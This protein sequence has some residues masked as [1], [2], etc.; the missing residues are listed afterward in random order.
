MQPTSVD[1]VGY[2][3]LLLQL[4]SSLLHEHALTR[5]PIMTFRYDRLN[6]PDRE[7]RIAVLQPGTFDDPLVVHFDR[8]DLAVLTP[9][10]L[11]ASMMLTVQK[12]GYPA[13]EA[14][15][16]VWGSEED[17]SHVKVNSPKKTG[18]VPITKNLDVALRHLRYE[19]TS[20][21]LWIDSIC[22][23]QSNNAEKSKQ[24][25]AMG[26]IF[27]TADRVTAWLG[28][29]E[30]NSDLAMAWFPIIERSLD[31]D[32]KSDTMRPRKREETE[33]RTG[34]QEQK[35]ADL[36]DFIAGRGFFPW[37]VEEA[38]AVYLLF[39]RPYF[40]RAWTVQEIRLAKHVF[41]QCGE[42]TISERSL[43][44]SA[45]LLD[46]NFKLN[47]GITSFERWTQARGRVFLLADFRM[48]G[49]GET[50]FTLRR[51]L[52]YL[53]CNDPRDKIYSVLRLMDSST[54]KLTI[55]PT[56]TQPTEQVYTD[57]ARRAIIQWSDLEVLNDCEL[58]SRL[59]NI[60]SWVPD[61]STPAQTTYA[62]T[63]WSACAYIA[64]RPSF[65]ASGLQC[66]V[67]GVFK[68]RIV[69]V[70]DQGDLKF[71]MSD[72]ELWK[73]IRSWRPAKESLNDI[74][75]TG[76]GLLEV[77]CRILVWNAFSERRLSF[78]QSLASLE[79]VWCGDARSSEHEFT[80]NLADKTSYFRRLAV[81]TR[82]RRLFK[83]SGGHLGLG[84]ADVRADDVVCILLGCRYPVILRLAA[85]RKYE[86]V[87]TCY[88]HGLMYGEILYD[89]EWTRKDNLHLHPVDPETG[90]SRHTTKGLLEKAGVRVDGKQ[91]EYPWTSSVSNETLLAAGIQ[92]EDFVLV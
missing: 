26:T 34:Q 61:W 14:L 28:S 13:Y 71:E 48:R 22:I 35:T 75:L 58:S 30:N 11:K 45:K 29:K 41:F 44:I 59:L 18:E 90:R 10:V 83:T 60:P 36:I 6:R 42:A 47:A 32:W 1:A 72:D 46:S 38:E 39:S 8:R 78:A 88:A 50:I 62:A 40:G 51:N 19:E 17:P 55:V 82:N 73:T 79:K 70:M 9:L 57:L 2:G 52:G 37:T 7:I 31:V 5:S 20:R 86:V 4:C 76:E 77:Y 87:G 69:E 85:D 92:V 3:C 81:I 64:G 25:A 65:D 21:Y 33:K 68:S 56:Y 63:E 80:R 23:N 53:L 12:K 43:W 15:S 54:Q 49:V 89:N 91:K 66:T 84:P 24:V 16:Y 67:S 27:K 74:Y